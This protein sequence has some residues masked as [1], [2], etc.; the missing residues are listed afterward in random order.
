MK[1]RN[2]LKT[3]ASGL[4][5]SNLTNLSCASHTSAKTPGTGEY[6][7]QGRIPGYKDHRIIDPGLKIKKIE[8]FSKPEVAFVRITTDNNMQG[9]GQISTYNSDITSLLLH[10]DIANRVLGKDPA[11]I[12]EIVDHCI[13]SNLKYPWSYICRALGGVDTAIWDLY[14]KIRQKPVCELLGGET[15]PFP[16][17]GSSMSRSIKPEDELKR[18]IK[19]RDE[20]GIRF[21]KFRI[22]TSN[23]RNKDAWPG[24]TEEM[25]KTI[26]GSLSDTCSLKAD[27]NS[28]YTPDKAIEV[29]KLMQ[30][31]HVKQF[32]EPCPY[33]ELEWTAE[34]TEALDLEISGGEQD[35]DLAQWRRMIEMKAVD[36]VQPDI[37]YVGGFT[38][39]LRVAL[40]ANEKGLPCIPH[41][42]N[43]CL[44]TPFTLHLMRSIPNPGNSMEY[45][46][47]YDEEINKVAKDLY[48]PLPE[49]KDGH[50]N[51]PP[52]PG[53]G[54]TIHEEWLKS[55]DYMVSEVSKYLGAQS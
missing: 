35:N 50:L 27:G 53:W 14:G 48:S 42:A 45:S 22:G 16:V 38:R 20:I 2:F 23:G 18:F 40:I 24:R 32:E 9:W 17:Y 8:T 28:C 25:I 30:E 7:H 12:D 34:V 47:E 19:Q 13:E 37:L 52:E 44:I 49:I 36:I 31:Y 15:K 33:W 55:A 26:G 5:A 3:S 43:H 1:R 10:R 21:F 6:L 39:A 4:I 51:M 46:I 41:S 54:I 11:N 29:G